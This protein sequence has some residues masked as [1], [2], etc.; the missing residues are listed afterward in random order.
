M[1]KRRVLLVAA[2]VILAALAFAEPV[3][4]DGMIIAP[5]TLDVNVGIGYG[6]VWG[7][8][9]GGGAEFAIGKFMIGESLPF[10]YGVAARAGLGIGDTFPLS[11]AALGTVHFCWGAIEW[12]DELAWLANVDSYIGLGLQIL[13]GLYITSISG[14][15]YFI[16]EHFAINVEGGLRASYLGVL[17]KF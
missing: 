3:A 8:D 1:A 5:G 17:Y 2:L 14:S 12:P 15:S 13:P 10:S 4:K 11:L 16:N 7:L 6:Y 9:I